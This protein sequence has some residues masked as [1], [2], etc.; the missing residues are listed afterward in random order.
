MKLNKKIFSL[1]VAAGLTLT[2]AITAF[3]SPV[4]DIQ[5]ALTKAGL[6]SVDTGKVV[7]YLQKVTITDA[8]ANAAIAKIDDA[9]QLAGGQAD[10][11]KLSSSVRDQIKTDITAAA[12][13]IGL[14]ADFGQ[15]SSTGATLLTIKDSNGTV[16]ASGD[17]N[18]A[19]S[20]VT[21]FDA[22]A[23]KAV[24]T[25]AESFSNNADKA[26]YVAVNGAYMKKTATNYGNMMAVGGILVIGSL[27]ALFLVKRQ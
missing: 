18:T 22:S 2:S 1:I 12:S 27:G 17:V 20:V 14:T 3:A 24:I 4:D 23:L 8:Q 6:S 15:T 7:E 16:L 19:K 10:L 9:A 25:A 26:K 21:S 13:S 5:A 11:T